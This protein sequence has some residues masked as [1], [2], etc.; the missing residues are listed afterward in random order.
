MSKIGR[1]MPRARSYEEF[2][3]IVSEVLYEIDE[4]RAS[5]EFDGDYMNDSL[6]IAESIERPMKQLKQQLEDGSYQHSKEGFAFIEN[7]QR[8]PMEIVP[9]RPL[10]T[11]INE[12][13]K[14]GLESDEDS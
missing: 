14:N 2:K 3:E 12:T 10:L 1:G 13:H 11:R 5:H 9:F 6:Q 7:M 4:I 8:V